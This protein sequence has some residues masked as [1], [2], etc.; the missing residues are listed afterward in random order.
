M[1]DML[2][3]TRGM[4]PARSKYIQSDRKRRDTYGPKLPFEIGIFK[5]K[6]GTKPREIEIICSGCGESI[7]VTKITLCVICSGCHTINKC[8]QTNES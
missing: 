1:S 8:E 3:E 7:F 4:T 6:L 2:D 5:K